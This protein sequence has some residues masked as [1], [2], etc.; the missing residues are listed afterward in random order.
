[1]ADTKIGDIKYN[2][3]G[4]NCSPTSSFLYTRIEDVDYSAVAI[5]DGS[6][7]LDGQFIVAPASTGTSGWVT[8]LDAT[9][10]KF[11]SDTLTDLA[12]AQGTGL[13]MV[14]QSQFK[15]DQD[16]LGSAKVPVVRGSL[17]VK[18]KLFGKPTAVAIATA[19]AA[20]TQLTVQMV[21][22]TVVSGT[23]KRLVLFPVSKKTAWVVGFVTQVVSD[24]AGSEEIEVQLYEFPRQVSL[25]A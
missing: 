10:L 5:T 11:Q 25:N 20:G 4:I 17:R 13:A 14:W 1:M 3:K 16:A 19:Y 24:V 15:T 6:G 2:T 8:D 12:E 21:D 7:P 22:V 18:T 9:N 23:Y